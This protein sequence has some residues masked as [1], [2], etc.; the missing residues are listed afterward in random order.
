MPTESREQHPAEQVVARDAANVGKIRAGGRARSARMF[1]RASVGRAPELSRSLASRTHIFPPTRLSCIM[2]MSLEVDMIAHR[3]ETTLNQDGTLT[4]DNL[5]FH[6]G[7]AVEIIIL[8]QAANVHHQKH[9]SLRGTAVRY[10]R[11]TELVAHDEW[12]AAA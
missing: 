3:V 7:E 9:Y 6:A 2:Q 10:D 8:S 11:P 1:H 12:D 5:P 4:L